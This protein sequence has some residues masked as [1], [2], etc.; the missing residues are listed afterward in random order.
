V[1]QYGIRPNP[2]LPEVPRVI[3]YAKTPADHAALSLLFNTQ[4]FGRPYILPPGTPPAI[5]ETMRASFASVMRDPAFRAEAAQRGLD[6]DPTSGEEIEGLVAEIYATP[7]D[8]VARVAAALE[9]AGK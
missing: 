9:Q 8:T 3:S 7:P 1:A 5:L 4:E 2:E 6:I